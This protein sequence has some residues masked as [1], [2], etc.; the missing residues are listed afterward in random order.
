[1]ISLPQI[2]VLQKQWPHEACGTSSI[3][4]AADELSEL[5]EKA[6]RHRLFTLSHLEAAVE[7]ARHR[8]DANK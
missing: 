6:L 1:M 8:I 3:V 7:A 5:L 2:F 4:V